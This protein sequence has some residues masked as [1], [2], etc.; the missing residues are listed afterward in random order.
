MTGLGTHPNNGNSASTLA[1]MVG[2]K[3]DG[4]SCGTLYTSFSGTY[5]SQYG[6]F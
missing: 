1:G 6:L 5:G 3:V 4:L 2:S